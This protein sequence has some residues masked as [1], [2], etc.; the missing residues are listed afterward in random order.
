MKLE[1]RIYKWIKKEKYNKEFETEVKSEVNDKQ[2]NENVEIDKNVN[3]E[4]EEKK[5]Y[6][7]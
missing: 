3:D 7:L 6:E 4:I 2:A 1:K 5:E